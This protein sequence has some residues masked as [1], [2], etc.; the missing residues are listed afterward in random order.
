MKQKDSRYGW[1]T[2]P[3]FGERIGRGRTAAYEIVKR[4]E[5]RTRNIGTAKRPALRIT[6]EDFEAF[7]RACCVDPKP[8]SRKGRAA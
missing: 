3:E 4:G 6:P 2:I 8:V 1:M 5:I 7:G